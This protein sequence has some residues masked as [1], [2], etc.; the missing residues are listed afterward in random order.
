MALAPLLLSDMTKSAELFSVLHPPSPQL[1]LLQPAPIQVLSESESILTPA[2]PLGPPQP[3]MVTITVQLRTRSKPLQ[4]HPM[5]LAWDTWDS[6]SP[7][8]K[9]L[10]EEIIIYYYI[11]IISL[12]ILNP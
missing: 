12:R 1:L 3:L 7:T 8:G 9:I 2:R 4:L 10:A 6:G 11:N 5:E